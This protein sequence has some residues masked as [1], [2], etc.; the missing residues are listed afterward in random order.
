MSRLLRLLT[1]P[2]VALAAYALKGPPD[3]L[4]PS[5]PEDGVGPLTRRRYWVEVEGATRTP[6]AVAEHWRNHL[7]DHAPKWLAWFRGLDHPVPPVEKGDRLGIRMLLI[8]RGYVV[9]EH[10]D[11]L[12]FRVRTLR[13]HP[14]AGTSD[15]RVYPQEEPGRLVLQIESLLRTNSQFDRLAYIFGVH[16]AQRRNWELTLTSVAGYSGGR[17]VSRGHESLEMPQVA[18]SYTLP[19]LPE[20]PVGLEPSSSAQT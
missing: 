15:F 12:G 2:A 10:I 9:V 13:L 14:D 20:A 18:H 7:P 4:R 6:E 19:E 3:P 1:L 8:R 17:I 11:P 5:G 16:A